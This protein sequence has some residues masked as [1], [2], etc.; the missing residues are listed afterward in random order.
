ML[1]Q[2]LA[3]LHSYRLV[4]FVPLQNPQFNGAVKTLLKEVH[5]SIKCFNSHMPYKNCVCIYI[6]IYMLLQFTWFVHNPFYLFSYP[7]KIL[8]L[9]H[10][11]VEPYSHPLTDMLIYD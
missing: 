1:I 3:S 7:A 6:S 10:I 11:I 8:G 4:K 9:L 2:S 5:P